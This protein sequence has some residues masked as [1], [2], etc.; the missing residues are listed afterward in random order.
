MKLL[1][2]IFCYTECIWFPA[3]PFL[4]NYWTSHLCKSA[5]HT[6]ICCFCIFVW[7]WSPIYHLLRKFCVPTFSGDSFD[8]CFYVFFKAFCPPPPTVNC[9]PFLLLVHFFCCLML[10][11]P[12]NGLHAAKKPDH[13]SA[14][15]SAFY[16]CCFSSDQSKKSESTT[17]MMYARGDPK[18]ICNFCIYVENNGEKCIHRY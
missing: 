1:Q 13:G 8:L 14:V 4:M 11:L 15:C 18:Q 5:L 9:S 2:V 16:A 10:Y 7:N 12:V 3:P 17:Q 6:L